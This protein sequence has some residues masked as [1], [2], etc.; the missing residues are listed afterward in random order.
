VVDIQ[1]SSIG[2]LRELR[3]PD[4][5]GEL[6]QRWIALLDQGTDELELMGTHLD[7]GRRAVAATYADNA[8]KLLQ[9]ARVLV[10]PHGVT[11]CRGPAF[12]LT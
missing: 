3:V 5:F 8:S 9:R 10:A 6:S 7:H 12:V 1:R 4:R 2:D 11:S